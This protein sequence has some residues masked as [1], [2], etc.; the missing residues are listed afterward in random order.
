MNSHRTWPLHIFYTIII[1]VISVLLG[2]TLNSLRST[3]GDTA[4]AASVPT[5]NLR[6]LE[7]FQG[8]FTAIAKSAGPSVVNIHTEQ[9]VERRDSM[10][11]VFQQFFGRPSPFTYKEKLTSLGSGVI[12]RKDG[13]ILT[14]VHVIAGADRIRVQTSDG[15]SYQA[16]PAAISP[17]NDLAMI[18]IDASNLPVARLGNADT[19]QVGAW[20]IAVGSPFGLNETVTVGVISAKGRVLS[21]PNGGFKDLL[22][23]DAAINVGNSGGPLLDIYGNVIGINQAIFSPG[24]SGGNIGIGFA[25]P[26]NEKNRKLIQQMLS[27]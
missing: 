2:A 27:G 26:I 10:D 25:I 16:K 5:A 20:A 15:K 24:R 9:I 13:Y 19:T 18:K 7:S 1:I 4:Q 22:Q 17:G 14:N 8:A 3:Q 12:I 6:T 11:D 23:T 21:G